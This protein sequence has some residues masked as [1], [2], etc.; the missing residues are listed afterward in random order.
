MPK[1]NLN[2][3][4]ANRPTKEM[5]ELELDD[6]VF[7]IPLGSDI[8]YDDLLLLDTTAGQRTFFA[9]YI[10]AEIISTLTVEDM[11]DIMNGWSEATT[12]AAG[13]STGESSASR[14]L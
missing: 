10:P 5:F 2:A 6:K 14:D 8:L 7:K 13:I 9:R 3:K 4:R 11:T 12:K 1:F